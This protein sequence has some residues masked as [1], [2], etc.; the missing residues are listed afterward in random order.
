VYHDCK[1]CNGKG[2][3]TNGLNGESCAVCARRNLLLKHSPAIGLVCSVCKGHCKVEPTSSRL[4][5]RAAPIIAIYIVAAAIMI[6]AGGYEK[7]FNEVLAFVGTLTGTVT[8]F[9]FGGNRTL[10]K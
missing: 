5:N 4:K 10:N 6:I 7:H 9:Y 1:H 3:C 2:S 8:G